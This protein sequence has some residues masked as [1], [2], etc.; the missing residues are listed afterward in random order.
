MASANV[1]TLMC[2]TPS[3]GIS[4][5]LLLSEWPEDKQRNCMLLRCS[6]M[7]LE[8]LE[9]TLLP[10]IWRVVLKLYNTICLYAWQSGYGCAPPDFLHHESGGP[11]FDSRGMVNQT[12]R[13][14]GVGELVATS[15][16][17]HGDRCCILRNLNRACLRCTACGL[18]SQVRKLGYHSSVSGLSTGL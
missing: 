12:V 7:R 15:R 11:G 14:S 5:H 1:C 16:L 13:T 6:A 3:H 17:M 8:K 18:C 4:E 9:I 2:Y 10:C